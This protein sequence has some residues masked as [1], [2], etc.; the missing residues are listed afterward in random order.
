[1]IRFK[2]EA[3][4]GLLVDGMR[5]TGRGLALAAG[6]SPVGTS[7][8]VITIPNGY[9]YQQT[10][11]YCGEAAMEMQLDSSAVTLNNPTVAAALANTQLLNGAGFSTVNENGAP[12]T[13]LPGDYALQN[14]LY[15][16]VYGGFAAA[17]FASHQ[18]TPPLAMA[19][20]M[21]A[22]DAPPSGIHNYAAYAFSP[23]VFEANGANRT[24][25]SRAESLFRYRPRQ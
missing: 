22:A 23:N 13:V 8:D 3:R 6:L 20:V 2:Y 19:G 18:G 25:R 11:F 24:A 10:A 5:A 16:S 12:T 21:N 7:A 15:G 9:H 1:M 17:A 4:R 14:Q